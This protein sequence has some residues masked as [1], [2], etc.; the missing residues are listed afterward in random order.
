VNDVSALLVVVVLV[1][2]SVVQVRLLDRLLKSG[3]GR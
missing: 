1:V 2:V 3:G